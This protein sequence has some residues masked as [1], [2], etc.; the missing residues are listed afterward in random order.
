MS[1]HNKVCLVTSA[2]FGVGKA[3]PLGLAELGTTMVML[4]RNRK[5]GEAAREEIISWSGHSRIDQMLADLSELSS[6]REF[7]TAFKS[8]YNRLQNSSSIKELPR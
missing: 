2:N 4:Y 1:M 3:T 7:V 6:I 8:K 5:R